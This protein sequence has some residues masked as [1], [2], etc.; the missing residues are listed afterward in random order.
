M[1]ISIKLLLIIPLVLV[2]IYF[3]IRSKDKLSFR[4]IYL[5]ISLIGIVFVLSPDLTNKI[6]RHMHVGRGADLI[7]YFFMVMAFSFSIYLYSKIRNI[8][9]VQTRIIR[10]ISIKNMEQDK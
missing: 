1:F 8:I 2:A 4:L 10:E 7:T 9:I 6:A 3:L 5:F